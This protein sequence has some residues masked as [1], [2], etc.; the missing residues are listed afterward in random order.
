MTETVLEIPASEF[1]ARCL[2]LMDEV[3]KT[4]RPW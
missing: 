1:K 3:R 4:R 2:K